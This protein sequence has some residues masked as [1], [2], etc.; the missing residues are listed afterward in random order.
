MVAALG[1]PFTSSI[2]AE[3]V[4]LTESVTPITPP[5]VGPTGNILDESSANILGESNEEILE[6]IN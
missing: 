3:Q 5:P 1:R 6:E 2:Q 4:I